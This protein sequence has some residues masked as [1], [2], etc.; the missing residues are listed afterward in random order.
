MCCS[1]SSYIKQQPSFTF[2][3]CAVV[4]VARL[5]GLLLIVIFI[6][7]TPV[8]GLG[9]VVVYD[10]LGVCVEADGETKL[11]E[12]WLLR[13]FLSGA[14]SSSSVFNPPKYTNDTN[15]MILLFS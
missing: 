6:G 14:S 10:T 3:D 2:C 15:C 7:E 5:L 13:L 9:A 12:E 1:C 11:S 4:V 8:T